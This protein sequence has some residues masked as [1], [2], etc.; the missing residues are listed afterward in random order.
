MVFALGL[1]A[2]AASTGASTAA[3]VTVELPAASP[4]PSSAPAP[5]ASA[6]AKPP[7]AVTA[8]PVAEAP[9]GPVPEPRV[10]IIT[11]VPG[12]GPEARPGDVLLVHYVG[13]FTD[14]KEFDSSRRPN[15]QPFRFT[16]GKGT[17]IKGWEQ[18]LLGMQVGEKRQLVIP[19][20]LAYGAKARPGIPENSTL[21]FDV[22]MLA[23]NPQP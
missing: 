4:S 3:P 8:R 7:P 6:A 14:G 5:V 10:K 9:A 20:E 17:V 13:T 21:L 16:L 1:V 2:C 12:S 23:I 18:G 15:R 22:E 19:P 11:L